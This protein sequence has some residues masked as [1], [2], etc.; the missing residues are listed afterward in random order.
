MFALAQIKKFEENPKEMNL[1]RPLEPPDG[2][3]IGGAASGIE[4]WLCDRER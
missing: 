2:Q 3:P 1:P 4:F